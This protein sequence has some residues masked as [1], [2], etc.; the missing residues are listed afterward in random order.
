MPIPIS[1]TSINNKINKR[2]VQSDRT[3]TRGKWRRKCRWVRSKYWIRGSLHLGNGARFLVWRKGR[4]ELI[5]KIV[6]QEIL[7]WRG[8]LLFMMIIRIRISIVAIWN[9]RNSRK[10]ENDIW[11]ALSTIRTTNSS[12]TWWSNT[13]KSQSCSWCNIR[14]KKTS[15]KTTSRGR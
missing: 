8:I 12:S 3:K 11:V 2:I 9:R 14:L 5:K 10:R 1:N 13:T 4:P 7:R 15:S 6:F